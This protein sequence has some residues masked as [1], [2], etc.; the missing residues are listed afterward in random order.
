M[1]VALRAAVALGH[2]STLPIDSARR[3]VVV[4]DRAG[5]APVAGSVALRGCSGRRRTSRRAR[6]A[7]SPLTATVTRLRRV[8]PGRR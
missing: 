4:D 5:A 7:V 6:P 8:R 1:K 3:G 2:A